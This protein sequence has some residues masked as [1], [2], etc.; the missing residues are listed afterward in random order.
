MLRWTQQVEMQTLHWPL[1]ICLSVCACLSVYLCQVANMRHGDD[2]SLGFW[3]W[4]GS[5]LCG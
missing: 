5:E 2:D 1:H 4:V 3:L